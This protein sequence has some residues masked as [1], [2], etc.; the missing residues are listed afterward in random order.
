MHSGCP[1]SKMMSSGGEA[2]LSNWPVQIKL[3]PA[4]AP[5]FKDADILIAADCVPFAYPDFHEKLLKG[6]I[7]M[8]GCPKL[9][10]LRL[11]KE[12]ITEII[13]NNTI[14]AITYARMEVPCC[15]GLVT[16]A[17]EAI[18]AS[19]KDV[20]FEETVISIKGACLK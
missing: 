4:N 10:D 19:G 3:I 8:V 5:Y 18:A 16:A 12:K 14:K 13:K 20:P 11:Y 2:P 15:S 9:D 6:K 1:G 7:L 17:K